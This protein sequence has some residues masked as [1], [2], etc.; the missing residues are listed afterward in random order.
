MHVEFLTCIKYASPVLVVEQGGC[1]SL[2][3]SAN[4]R[5]L[6]HTHNQMVDHY[7]MPITISS[8]IINAHY[9]VFVH[10]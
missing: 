9:S 5:A 2:G 6:L 4:D 3:A 1:S 10:K 7:K 8:C